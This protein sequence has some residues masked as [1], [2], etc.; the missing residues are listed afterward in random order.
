MEPAYG[1]SVCAIEPIPQP[2][3]AGFLFSV[4]LV[5][6]RVDLIGYS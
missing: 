4:K 5:T 2:A 3:Y 6:A 1:S